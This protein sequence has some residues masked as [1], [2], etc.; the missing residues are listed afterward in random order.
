[1]N[2]VRSALVTGREQLFGH[3]QAVRE[4][5]LMLN[6]DLPDGPGAQ[7]G[8]ILDDDALFRCDQLVIGLHDTE[9][10]QMAGLRAPL[11]ERH[12]YSAIAERGPVLVGER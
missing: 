9:D 3:R 7:A 11:V 1:M 12:A 6:Q 5:R 8:I 2:Q 4:S 10:I